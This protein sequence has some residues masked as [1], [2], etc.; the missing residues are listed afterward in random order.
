MGNE[1]DI[2]IVD[3]PGYMEWSNKKI[4]SGG[5]ADLIANLDSTCMW[6]SPEEINEV[7]INDF[8]EMYQELV[9]ELDE[10]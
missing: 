2:R 5:S 6:L 1:S 3:I 9:D 4:E 10:S 8:E 7:T